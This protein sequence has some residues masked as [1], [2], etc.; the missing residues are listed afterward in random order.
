MP[1]IILLESGRA[2][3]ILVPGPWDLCLWLL[4]V[5]VEYLSPY[6]LAWGLFWNLWRSR[7]HAWERISMFW[8]WILGSTCGGDQNGYSRLG[9]H[10]DRT[11]EWHLA[12]EFKQ[13]PFSLHVELGDWR[14][15]DQKGPTQDFILGFCS[16]TAVWRSFCM[17]PVFFFWIM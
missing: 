9:H 11:W 16:Q 5:P 3:F 1:E 17:G 7:M 10:G 12:F 8:P 2:W 4:S 6:R 15:P 13:L 14:T